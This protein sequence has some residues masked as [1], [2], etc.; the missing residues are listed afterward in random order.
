M[1][2]NI[3]DLKWDEELCT[4]L[5]IPMSMLLEVK[6]SPEIYTKTALSIFFGED[7]PLAGTIGLTSN[8]ETISVL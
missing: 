7:I 1:L 2:Y 8:K 4:L 6:I 5:N 3:Y